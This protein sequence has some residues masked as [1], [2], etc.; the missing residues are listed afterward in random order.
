MSKPVGAYKPATSGSIFLQ[1]WCVSYPKH[2][3]GVT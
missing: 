3:A 2:N 1:G